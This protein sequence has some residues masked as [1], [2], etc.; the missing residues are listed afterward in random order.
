M[1]TCSTIAVCTSWARARVYSTAIVASCGMIWGS[2]LPSHWF[3]PT[4]QSDSGISA[5]CGRVLMTCCAISEAR[6][7][8]RLALAVAESFMSQA[9]AAASTA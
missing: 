5:A 4:I 7:Q 6:A 3:M 9:C 1:R 8:M 2:T